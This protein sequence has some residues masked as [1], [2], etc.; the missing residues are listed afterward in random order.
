MIKHQKNKLKCAVKMW[1]SQQSSEGGYSNPG[2]SVPTNSLAKGDTL[3]QA[4][5]SQPNSPA[6]T[7]TLNQATVSQPIA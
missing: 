1:K 7:D 2:Y 6:Q 5:V 4:T 3:T